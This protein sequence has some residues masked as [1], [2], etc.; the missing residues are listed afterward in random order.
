MTRK[1][2]IKIADAIHYEFSIDQNYTRQQIA[3]IIA[4]ALR[5]TNPNYDEGRFYVACVN[6]R[7]RK[8]KKAA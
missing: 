8:T 5:G 6:G 2:Y 3:A 4:R 7:N 1:H